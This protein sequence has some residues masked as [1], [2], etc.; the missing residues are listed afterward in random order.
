M[1]TLQDNPMQE[2]F[3][4]HYS[5]KRAR[6]EGQRCE[7]FGNDLELGFNMLIV[8]QYHFPPLPPM[9]YTGFGFFIFWG[10]IHGSLG[11]FSV[12][13]KL[14]RGGGLKGISCKKLCFKLKWRR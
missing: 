9:S 14:L 10:I 13:L 11:G 4:S 6:S 1:H 5:D 7:R 3:E 12:V 8:L 2:G